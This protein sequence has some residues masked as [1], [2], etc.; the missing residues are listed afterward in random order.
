VNLADGRLSPAP[1]TDGIVS[2]SPG[3]ILFVA[4]RTPVDDVA[5]LVAVVQGSTGDSPGRQLARQLATLVGADADTT[6]PGFALVASSPG[7]T[8]VRAYGSVEVRLHGDGGEEVI[9]AVG[10]LTGVDRELAGP[11]DTVVAHRA[12]EPVPAPLFDVDLQAGTVPAGGFALTSMT[13]PDDAVAVAPPAAEPLADAPAAGSP[14][15]HDVPPLTAAAGASTLG[16]AVVGAAAVAAAGTHDEDPVAPVADEPVAPTDALAEEQAETVAEVPVADGVPLVGEEAAEAIG[17]DVSGWTQEP[18]EA[19]SPSTEDLAPDAGD[20]VPAVPLAAPLDIPPPLEVPAEAVAAE[21]PPLDA[22][23]ATEEPPPYEPPTLPP[24]AIPPVEAAPAAAAAGAGFT[25][26]LLGALDNDEVDERDALPVELDPAEV[27]APDQVTDEV[28]VQGIV[29]SRGHFNDPRSRF[30][31]S[32]GISMVQ[33][34]QVL[35]QGPRPPLGVMVFEDG[36]TFS[37]STDYVVGR[38]P[39]VHDLVQQGLALPI[40]VDDPERSI[41]RAHAELRLVDWDVH[42]VNLSG[43]NGSFVWDETSQQWIPIPEGQ[44]V[45]LMP[46]M[47]VALGRRSAVF[48]SS[49]VR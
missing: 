33:N 1:G 25:S 44:S 18:T 6:L 37:L 10:S 5:R 32:C 34:T 21:Q 46:G 48:E 42:L 23:A 40:T 7:G 9:S 29:C 12:G 22:P 3:A 36:A 35:T 15:D 24:S 4:A 2:R 31:S 41:S 28:R 14:H 49:L 19:W 43:T 26:V 47:R 27:R 20:E 11:F 8:Y 16:P 38:Q 39:E 45:Q 30:C 13:G 17:A